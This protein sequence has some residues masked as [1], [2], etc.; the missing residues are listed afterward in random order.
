MQRNSQEVFDYLTPDD[1]SD[2]RFSWFSKMNPKE[3]HMT[4][5]SYIEYFI[6]EKWGIVHLPYF[7]RKYIAKLIQRFSEIAMGIGE[8]Y[9]EWSDHFYKTD[10]E[11][12]LYIATGIAGR[13]DIRGS[14]DYY[15]DILKK[16]NQ[17]TRTSWK[18]KQA[19]QIFSSKLSKQISDLFFS[20]M[21]QENTSEDLLE[22]WI[23]FVK[24]LR[25]PGNISLRNPRLAEHICVNILRRPKGVMERLDSVFLLDFSDPEIGEKSPSGVIQECKTELQNIWIQNH[26]SIFQDLDI[27]THLLVGENSDKVPKSYESANFK[28]KWDLSLLARLTKKIQKNDIWS[29]EFSQLSQIE[30]WQKILAISSE[31]YEDSIKAV[32]ESYDTTIGSKYKKYSHFIETISPYISKSEKEAFEIFWDIRGYWF[33][34]L[35]DEKQNFASESWK[36]VWTILATIWVVMAVTA[37]SGWLGAGPLLAIWV[38]ASVG[39]AANIGF[40][41][42]RRHDSWWEMLTDVWSDFVINTMHAV[43]MEKVTIALWKGSSWLWK[44][45]IL[46]TDFWSGIYIEWVREDIISSWFRWE[47]LIW[48]TTKGIAKTLSSWWFTKH[49]NNHYA[50]KAGLESKDPEIQKRLTELETSFIEAARF[51]NAWNYKKL[52]FEDIPLF[53]NWFDTHMNSFHRQIS[54]QWTLEF[55][56]LVESWSSEQLKKY[57]PKQ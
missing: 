14:L 31:I 53:K 8:E 45:G 18:T 30:Q 48:D 7:Q 36:A 43:Y 26:T 52:I 11:I 16:I 35:S 1:S 22:Q 24:I 20:E 29:K 51:Y 38:W 46:G 28:Q 15:E 3:L 19:Q 37:I 27:D 4:V 21:Q 47:P 12:D 5:R 23:R 40:L 54:K 55:L 32:Q 42:K 44:T 56:D 17:N 9:E 25:D 39:T 13:W 33:F 57:W 41:D 34:D 10:Q 50:R 2:S 49:S 6:K